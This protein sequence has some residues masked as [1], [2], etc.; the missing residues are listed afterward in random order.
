ME[1]KANQHLDNLQALTLGANVCARS[2]ARKKD[3]GAQLFE[4]PPPTRLAC[5]RAICPKKMKLFEHSLV[6]NQSDAQK[7][8]FTLQSEISR[9]FERTQKADLWRK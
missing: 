9:F 4:I 8:T 5:W 3:I 7:Q 6:R 1:G 2:A